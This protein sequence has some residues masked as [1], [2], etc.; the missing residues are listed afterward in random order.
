[1]KLDD[2]S[3]YGYFRNLPNVE[4]GAED[5]RVQICLWFINNIMISVY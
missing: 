1:M 5:T 3:R 2:V 4:W